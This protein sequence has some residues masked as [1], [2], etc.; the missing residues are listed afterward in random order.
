V[1][2]VTGDFPSCWEVEVMDKGSAEDGK[3]ENEDVYTRYVEVVV[4]W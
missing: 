1:E 3:E 4:F 2:V